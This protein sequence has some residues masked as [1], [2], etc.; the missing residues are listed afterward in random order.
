MDRVYSVTCRTDRTAHKG[1]CYTLEDNYGGPNQDAAGKINLCRLQD[2]MIRNKSYIES[3]ETTRSLD[4][5]R[6]PKLR[7]GCSSY[8]GWADRARVSAGWN[9]AYNSDAG[10]R[11]RYCD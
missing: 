6:D 1:S 11:D 10:Y 3:K 9:N 8:G 7:S 4:E 2:G 5:D